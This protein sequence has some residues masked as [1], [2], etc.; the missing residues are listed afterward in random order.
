MY[1]MAK[2]TKKRI[3]SSEIS[4][5]EHGIRKPT[6]ERVGAYLAL[7]GVEFD[8]IALEIIRLLV[9]DYFSR[10]EQGYE[11]EMAKLA[12]SA[13]DGSAGDGAEGGIETSDQDG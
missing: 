3:G 12:G 10:M 13:I 7:L 2:K 11:D 4:R 9:K 1:D 5:W 6:P 8:E